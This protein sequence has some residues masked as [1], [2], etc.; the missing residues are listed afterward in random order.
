MSETVSL[1]LQLEKFP[2]NMWGHHF[3]VSDEVAKMFISGKDRR[4]ICDF[5]QKEVKHCALMPS[6][7]GYFILADKRLR[8]AL[9]IESGD[10]VNVK[11]QKD[12]SKYGMPFPEELKACMEMEPKSADF[13]EKLSPGKQR[14]LIHMVGKI[15]SKDIRIRRSLSILEHLK[16]ES[17]ELDGKKLNEVIKEFNQREKL[18]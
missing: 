14:S 18:L 4:I 17:G 15:K 13:F 11:I 3:R 1:K 8:K 7:E 5:E 16:R 9:Q 10:W 2:D 6:P 12:K